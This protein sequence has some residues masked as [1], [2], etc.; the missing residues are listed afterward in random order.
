[1]E[2]NNQYRAMSEAYF[3][4]RLPREQ[5]QVL[6]DWL[7][8]DKANESLFRAWEREW[9]ESEDCQRQTDAAWKR[10][11]RMQKDVSS[12]KNTPPQ[13]LRP[14]RQ[15][16][17][18]FAVAAAALLLLIAYP[19]VRFFLPLSQNETPMLVQTQTIRIAADTVQTYSLP[20]QT[21]VQLSQ[22]ARLTYSSEYGKQQRAVALQGT[23]RFDVMKNTDCPFTVQATP[24]LVEVTGTVFTVQ[25][26]STEVLA[27]VLLH[28]GAVVVHCDD[29][30]YLLAPNEEL[31]YHKQ[32]RQVRYASQSLGGVL[33]RLE[34]RTGRVIRFD[35]SETMRLCVR[36]NTH[37]QQPAEEV[38]EALA[39]LY[40]LDIHYQGDTCIVCAR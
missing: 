5:Q 9:A 30:T 24:L 3:R 29:T 25:A 27:R 12:I 38:L 14:L 1:M 7:Q 39:E 16:R 36:Y 37:S 15:K 35:D 13:A 2:T 6:S 34:Q 10:F 23:A 21:K 26:D 17:I 22:G 11:R 40:A 20:D 28:E 33:R 18:L 31:T 8:A 19:L 4:G 32:T